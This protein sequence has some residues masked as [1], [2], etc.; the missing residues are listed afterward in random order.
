MSRRYDEFF[1]KFLILIIAFIILLFMIGFMAAERKTQPPNQTAVEQEEDDDDDWDF[2]KKKHK[3]SS[4]VPSHTTGNV[5]K[6]KNATPAPALKSTPAPAVKQAT[7]YR[8]TTQ[9]FS[10][11]TRRK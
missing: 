9:S 2:D 8:P 5:Y 11:T 4:A 1:P 10:N 7:V 6:S 3:P